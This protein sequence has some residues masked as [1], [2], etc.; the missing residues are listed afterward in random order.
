MADFTLLGVIWQ[1]GVGRRGVTEKVSSEW[2]L[3]GGE[4][5]SKAASR[6]GEPLGVRAAAMS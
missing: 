4:D 5:L 1:G 6:S 2:P 3:A